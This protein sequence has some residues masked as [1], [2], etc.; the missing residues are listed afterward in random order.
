MADLYATDEPREAIGHLR[1]VVGA[2][3]RIV[4]Y[5]FPALL[6]LRTAPVES[7]RAAG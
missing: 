2:N 7:L 4:L 3:L 5:L 1:A 6:S